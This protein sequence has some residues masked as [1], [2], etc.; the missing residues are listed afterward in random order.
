MTCLG[1]ILW[2]FLCGLWS[3][4]AWALAG[5][6]WCIT[7]VGIPVGIQCFKF[8]QLAFCPFGR[9]IQFGTGTVSVLLNILWLMFSGLPMAA[10]FAIAGCFLCVTVVGIPF[11]LQLFKFAKLALMP[12]GASVL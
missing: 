3:G 5:A 10:G 6:L 7:V 9:E 12:F 2:F 4:L 1:N 11:G 8:A